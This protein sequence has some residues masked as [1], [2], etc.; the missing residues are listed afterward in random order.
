MNFY[1]SNLSHHF[2]DR[3]WWLKKFQYKLFRCV[4][5]WFMIILL[6]E[7]EPCYKVVASQNLQKKG[8]GVDGNVFISGFN[9]VCDVFNYTACLHR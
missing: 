9:L 3:R 1:E 8:G 4:G 5:M 7:K 2:Q 6:H